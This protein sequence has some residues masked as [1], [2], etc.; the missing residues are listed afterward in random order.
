MYNKLLSKFQQ[1]AKGWDPVSASY[2][3]KYCQENFDV[4]DNTLLNEFDT[5]SD[6]FKNKRVV[7][8]GA[9]PGQYSLEFLKRDAQ[10]TWWDVSRRYLQFA[11]HKIKQAGY[12]AQFRLDYMDHLNGTFD[13]VFNRV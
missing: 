4:I 2:A 6:G 3:A 1:P 13:V 5:W 9:G 7:D 11:E 8:L 10:V 12:D